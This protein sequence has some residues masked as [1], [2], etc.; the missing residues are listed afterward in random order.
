MLRKLTGLLVALAA[1]LALLVVPAGALACNSTSA[2]CVYS[3]GSVG[4]GGG[5]SS[6]GGGGGGSSGGSPG[7]NLAP[8]PVSSHVTGALSRS[9]IPQSDKT[10]LKTLM[11]NPAFGKT[12][13]LTAVSPESVAAPSALNAVF[14]LGAG[15][16]ALIAILIGSAILL[17][18]GTGWRGWRRWRG[19]LLA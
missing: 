8:A 11:K 4:P 3:P 1:A 5:H 2:V 6:G 12:R 10:A 18:A 14:D 15:P 19:R 17:L 13:G 9:S 16:V 7:Q